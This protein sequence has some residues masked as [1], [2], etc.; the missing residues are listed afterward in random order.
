MIR[1]L[2]RNTRDAS[3]RTP[4]L[5]DSS[6]R[7]SMNILLTCMHE[8]RLVVRCG[9]WRKSDITREGEIYSGGIVSTSAAQI[10]GT[11]FFVVIEKVVV[12]L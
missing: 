8:T 5:L 2:V 11:N 7:K 3:A 1:L 6:H 12:S 9:A 10:N 4:K